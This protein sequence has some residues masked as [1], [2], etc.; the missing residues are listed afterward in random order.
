MQMQLDSAQ[1]SY[2][3]QFPRLPL[4][5][6][7]EVAAHLQQVS[8]VTVELLPQTSPEFD[9]SQSQVGGLRIL[10]K[11]TVSPGDRQRLNQVLDYYSDRFGAWELLPKSQT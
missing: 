1:L 3:L 2:E 9:Y 8:G 11:A 6:Y 7:R 4:A 5:T 10:L